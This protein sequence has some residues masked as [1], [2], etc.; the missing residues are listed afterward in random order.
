MKKVASITLL[1]MAMFAALLGL[2]ACGSKKNAADRLY[3]NGYVRVTYD[4]GEGR[5][6]GKDRYA[7]FMTKQG[8]P[9]ICPGDK[10]F[11]EP[12]RDEYYID[13]WHLQTTDGEG[14]KTLASEYYDFR[15]PV[16]HDIVLVAEWSQGFYFRIVVAGE[17]VATYN[18][19]PGG[20][21]NLDS[22]TAPTRSG[23]T[24]LGYYCDEAC[25]VPFTSQTPHSE[26][27]PD[28]YVYTKWVEGNYTVVRNASEFVKA[29]STVTRGIYLMNDI[30]FTGVNWTRPAGYAQTIK[31]DGE[32]YTISNIT[33]SYEHNA[34]AGYDFGLFGS[35]S[36][37]I[38]GVTFKDCSLTFKLPTGFN[39]N[40]KAMNAGFLCGNLGATARISGVKLEN[41]S[42]KVE[43][44][45]N[46]FGYLYN[47]G[48]EDPWAGNHYFGI[49]SASLSEGAIVGTVDFSLTMYE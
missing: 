35:F 41:C 9:T 2:S 46:Q 24:L 12:I 36:G 47:G 29:L 49:S 37:S 45:S 14:N 27:E 33:Y 6:V 15:T 28:H 1:L 10:N 18:A 44:L 32:G 16:E 13:G 5:F 30:D 3:E 8:N 23:Y 4:A 34:N 7:Y 20:T 17:V 48:T 26:E 38:E 22:V 40:G 31:C 19:T 11:A 43:N 21:L 42:L 25:T 39:T